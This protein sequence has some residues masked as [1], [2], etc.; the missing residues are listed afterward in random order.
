MQFVLQTLCK[1]AGMDKKVRQSDHDRQARFLLV[2]FENLAAT[3]RITLSKTESTWGSLNWLLAI[4]AV[5]RT[6]IVKR[7]CTEVKMGNSL[8]QY[9]LIVGM[10]SV[11]LVAKEFRGC[12]KGKFWCFVLLVLLRGH[13]FASIETFCSYLWNVT[14]EL[15]VTYTD[16]FVSL[17]SWH[18][19][20]SNILSA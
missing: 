13:I 11:Y 18:L 1:R 17:F 16:L 9:R 6:V 20:S 3:L 7:A 2:I 12:F 4:C 14:N 15:P 5:L 19:H 10:H 8:Q